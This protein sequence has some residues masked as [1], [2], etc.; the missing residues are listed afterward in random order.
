VKDAVAVPFSFDRGS[1]YRQGARRGID[2]ASPRGTLVRAA[3]GGVVQ[4]AGRVP[5]GGFG[6]TVRCGALLATH[7]GVDAAIV[8]EGIRVDAGAVLGRVGPRGVLRLGARR[9]GDRHGYVDPAA[10]LRRHRG[11]APLA[12][13][14]RRTRRVPTI[15]RPPPAGRTVAPA[16]RAHWPGVEPAGGDV[17]AVAWVGLAVAGAGAGGGG[18]VRRRRSARARPLVVASTP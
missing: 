4:W 2:F 8:R 14:A 1:P 18:L 16:G 17:P 15:R 12:A 11:D 5:R 6:V 9:V 3:C 7:I 13:P 10:L